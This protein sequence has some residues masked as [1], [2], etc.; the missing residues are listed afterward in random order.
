MMNV[1]IIFYR[2]KLYHIIDIEKMGV[3]LFL[4]P[5]IVISRS[6]QNDDAIRLSQQVITITSLN[7]LI[8]FILEICIMVGQYTDL[9]DSL[10]SP[11]FQ[12]IV[13]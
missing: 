5:G 3:H 9:V 2:V 11:T 7:G 8:L 12:E 1:C 10:R 6:L 13:T 4:I